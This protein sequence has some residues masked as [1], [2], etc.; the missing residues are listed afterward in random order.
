MI[1]MKPL[2]SPFGERQQLKKLR[3]AERFPHP[4]S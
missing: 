3:Q 4:N 1:S 2:I